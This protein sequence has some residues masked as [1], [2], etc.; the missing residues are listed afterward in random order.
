MS[1]PAALGSQ[2]IGGARTLPASGL[3]WLPCA[4]AAF[5]AE[6]AVIYLIGSSPEGRAWMPVLLPAAHLLLVPFLIRNFSFWGA[7]VI[8]MGL[9]LNLI[10]MAVNGG[11]MPVGPRA[12]EAIG[13]HNLDE[14]PLG[15]PI[16]GSKNVLLEP[17]QTHAQWLS[18]AIVL[19]IPR[20]YKRAVSVGDLVVF[21]G[22]A[23]TFVEV[24]R[25]YRQS[26]PAR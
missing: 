10:V 9:G 14:L 26:Q 24:T 21:G 2:K 22:V 11:L 1:A 13:K 15:D 16:P 3:H 6:V 7:R 12:V 19:P 25:R 8:L 20:P 23:A 18:D 5:I 17:D 4:L